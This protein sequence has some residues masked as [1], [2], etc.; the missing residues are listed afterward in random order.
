M[1]SV[2]A[3]CGLALAAG[4]SGVLTALVPGR[5]SA[6]AGKLDPSVIYNY[7][8][9]ETTRSVAMGGALRAMGNGTSGIFLNP[10]AIV[11][12]RVYHIEAL[13]QI[14]PET[15]RQVYGGTVVD[16]VTGRLG[17][18]VSVLG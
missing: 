13:A 16:T 5:A 11:E 8:E 7:G 9:N 3:R 4:L 17:G 2:R 10:A 1:R 14:S 12:T 18:S 6:D 15:G